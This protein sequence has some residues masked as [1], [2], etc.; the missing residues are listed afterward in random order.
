VKLWLINLRGKEAHRVLCNSPVI[1]ITAGF[2]FES[3]TYAI[4]YF[5]VTILLRYALAV[6]SDI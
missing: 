5:S 1:Q 6:N 3:V 4:H 2:I